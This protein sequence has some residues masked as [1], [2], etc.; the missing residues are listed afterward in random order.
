MADKLISNSTI[1]IKFPIIT[2]RRKAFAELSAQTEGVRSKLMQVLCNRTAVH[3]TQLP[4][5]CRLPV[6]IAASARVKE[7]GRDMTGIPWEPVRNKCV[8]HRTQLYW[9][10]LVPSALVW[11]NLRCLLVHDGLYSH[12][13]LD[14][15]SLYMKKM[16]GPKSIGDV[17]L[18]LGDR[19]PLQ[20]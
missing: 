8:L 17:W 3:R 4:P 20:K 10:E 13:S 1:N 11:H 15:R 14:S 5:R 12:L 19:D 9:P 6:F 16:S 7:V 2:N 18:V